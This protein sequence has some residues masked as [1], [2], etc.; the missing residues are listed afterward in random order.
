V[1][2]TLVAALL[3][4]PPFFAFALWPLFTRSRTGALL[5]LPPDTRRQLL[6]RK[7]QVL[8]GLRELQF[9]HESGH[10]SDD[11]YR[12]LR[13]R[14]E[15]EASEILTELD[16]LGPAAAPVTTDASSATAPAARG[17]R[18]P[19]AMAAGAVALL[20]F[21]IALGAGVVRHSAPDPS[22]GVPLVGSRPLAPPLSSGGGESS[23]SDTGGGSPRAISPEMLQG[24]L[25]AARASLFAGRYGEAI[26]AY[27][28]VLKRDPKNVD[29]ITHLGLIVALGGHVDQALETLDRA[30]ALDP[31]YPPA[32]LY[33]G[34]VLLESKHD[35]AGAIESWERFV[36]VV[37][38][39]EERER[40]ARLLEQARSRH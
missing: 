18:H 39:G 34:Q 32:L 22:A 10:I 36:A 17:W 30:L 7:R 4:G 37:P 35:A 6:E 12:D 21:G 38:P 31:N 33:R 23:A 25:Q 13:A 24:M 2:G 27:Q 20:V 1:K 8:R 14:A 15:A 11:D 29:A 9:E 16:R 26:A 3:I 40:V 5:P 19:A 28:A